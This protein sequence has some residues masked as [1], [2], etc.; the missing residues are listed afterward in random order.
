MKERSKGL[1]KVADFEKGDF[2][3]NML[4]HTLFTDIKAEVA[5]IGPNLRQEV[6]QA[7]TG[8]L[9]AIK[10]LDAVTE[11]FMRASKR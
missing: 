9:V 3:M 10:E 2:R 11:K 4:C 7:F 5:D 1:K 6:A 8:V